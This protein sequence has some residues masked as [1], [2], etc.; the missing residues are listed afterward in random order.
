[1]RLQVI[2][3][4]QGKN[5]GVFIPMEDWT[6]IKNQYP[7][8]ESADLDLPKWEKDLIN[9]RLDAITK[10]PERLKSGKNLLKELK[11]KI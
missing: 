3:D 4:G 6:L 2:Q 10:N 5:T 11:R 9:D 7:D 8:I 1:M